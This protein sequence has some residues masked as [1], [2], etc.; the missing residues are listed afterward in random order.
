MTDLAKGGLEWPTYRHDAARSGRSVTAVPAEL[1]QKWTARIG[2]NLTAPVIARGKLI[3]ADKDTH[4]VF[5]LNAESGKPVWSFVAGGRVDS[6]PTIHRGRV[7]FGCRDGFAY[8]LDAGS[9]ALVW[10]YR[11]APAIRSLVA[12]EQI[13][14]LWPLHGS[15]LVLEDRLYCVA[16]RNM[17]LDGGMRFVCL[18]VDTGRLVSETVLGGVDPTTKKDLQFKMR[19]RSLPVALPDILSSDGKSIFMKSQK[20]TLDGRR[21]TVDPSRNAGDQTGPDAHLFAPGGFLDSTGFHRVCMLYGK[22]FTGGAGSN[23]AAQRAAPSGKMLVFDDSR[24]YGFSRLPHLHRWV[25]SLEFHIFAAD[26][27]NRRAMPPRRRRRAK[28]ETKKQ[29]PPSAGNMIVHMAGDNAKKRQ[30]VIG[31]LVGTRVKYE[32]S[33][34]DP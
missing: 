12:S 15:V 33:S 28:A 2:K 14:S 4:R 31:S 22:V 20:F 21:P 8:C 3:A 16:G 18:D 13:E 7:L 19:N 34:H 23:H 27:Y 26:K 17:F 10:R 9:G 32:W 29:P 5:A 25:R 11:A 24:V 1:K 6:P 30:R